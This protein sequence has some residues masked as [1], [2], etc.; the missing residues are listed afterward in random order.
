MANIGEHMRVIRVMRIPVAE[1]FDKLRN[2]LSKPPD[3]R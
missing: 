1:P 3:K 2:Q